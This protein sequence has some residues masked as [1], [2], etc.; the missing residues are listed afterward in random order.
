[1]EIVKDEE[2]TD[3]PTY[4][5]ERAYA[6]QLELLAVLHGDKVARTR[7]DDRGGIT[8]ELAA[9]GTVSF[10][11]GLLIGVLSALQLTTSRLVALETHSEA[12]EKAITT[13]VQQT[14]AMLQT[15]TQL[16]TY[17]RTKMDNPNKRDR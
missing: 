17:V 4:T 11:V 3:V 6:A 14:G 9:M 10:I 2:P 7:K 16:D 8:R 13:V 12:H 15:V 1:V 5:P